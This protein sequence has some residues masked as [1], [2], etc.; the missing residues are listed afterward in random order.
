[1]GLHL[2]TGSN[3]TYMAIQDGTG[4]ADDIAVHLQAGTHFRIAMTYVTDA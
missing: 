2:N 3:Y 4:T 1:M